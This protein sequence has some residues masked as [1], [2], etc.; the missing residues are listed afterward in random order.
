M[1]KMMFVLFLLPLLTGCG[2]FFMR[3]GWRNE[4]SDVPRFYPASYMDGVLLIA[5]CNPNF[6]EKSMPSR[7]GMTC[8]GLVDLPI[9]IVTDTLC[10]PLDIWVYESRK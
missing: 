10:I 9:S 5:P 8:I 1:K 4:L 7:L 2:T 3:T 6:A